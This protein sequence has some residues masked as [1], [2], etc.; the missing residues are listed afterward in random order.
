M[1]T[2]FA[3]WIANKLGDA[4]AFVTACLIILIWAIAGPFFN[5]TD[6]WQLI[7]NT[8]T[9][10]ITFLMVFLIQNTQN[11]EMFALHLK[12]DELIRS[13]H[14]THSEFLDIEDLTDEELE[15]IHKRYTELAHKVQLHLRKGH[16]DTE[17]PVK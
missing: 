7:I 11:R 15:A 3:K 6:T 16:N 12:I 17:T 13:I 9:S 1:F 4:K 8:G 2:V 5:F 10:V 14:G